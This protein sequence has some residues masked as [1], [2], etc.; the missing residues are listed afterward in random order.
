MGVNTGVYE[1]VT[2]LVWGDFQRV[3]LMQ[4]PAGLNIKT[5]LAEYLKL[6]GTRDPERFVLWLI[7]AKGLKRLTVSGGIVLDPVTLEV[8]PYA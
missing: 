8:N 6:G 1:I 7:R 2:E 3:A 5:L 4:G